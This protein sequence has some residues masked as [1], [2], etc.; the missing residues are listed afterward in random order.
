MLTVARVTFKRLLQE[1]PVLIA[2]FIIP[3]VIIL[4]FSKMSAVPT[5]ESIKYRVGIL[6]QDEHVLTP[7]QESRFTWVT[8]E[9]ED[10]LKNGVLRGLVSSGILFENEKVSEVLASNESFGS[11]IL[12][13]FYNERYEDDK[14]DISQDKNA[15][16]K[17]I[18]NFLINYMLFSMIFI[19]TDI[20]QLKNLNIFRRMGSMPLTSSQM[21]GGLLLAFTALLTL[22]VLEINFVIY[23][24]LGVP[25]SGNIIL[26]TLVF[27]LMS[28]VILSFGLLVTRFTENSSI[29]PI[30]CNF[31]A[32][33]LM[34]IS[35][36]F[37]PVDH[38]PIF[39][40]IKFI[41]PQYWVV[42]AVSVLNSG[43]GQVWLHLAV[44]FTMGFV[45]FSV[46]I[47]GRKPAMQ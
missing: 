10:A 1:K 34:M 11:F 33:P 13:E 4:V 18:L 22:Q 17:V 36:T 20:T 46:A 9:T 16:I 31:I 45:I 6:M 35:G 32:V 44:L 42:D 40:K 30:L 25:I 15:Q 19:A 23:M 41:S 2:L 29:I 37:M 24:V 26:S 27:M 5:E 3:V 43:Q 21:F 38:H 12:G 28:G 39:S 14:K 7:L 47:A 8:Y